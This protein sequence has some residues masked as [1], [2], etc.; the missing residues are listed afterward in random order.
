MLQEAESSRWPG[1]GASR[2][3]GS[4]AVEVVP[5]TANLSGAPGSIELN[6]CR[7]AGG[8]GDPAPDL[9]LVAGHPP[10]V[11]GVA[12]PWLLRY[13][14]GMRR[15]FFS[16]AKRC[17]EMV[18]WASV[19][20]PFIG[21]YAN[22]SVMEDQRGLFGFQRVE[23][24]DFLLKNANVVSCLVVALSLTWLDVVER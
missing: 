7:P 6:P 13:R 20:L 9:L 5:S 3:Q 18:R 2:M 12:P 11:D 15:E 1:L 17:E 14:E 19:G 10:V 4:G 24:N 22:S 8:S 21:L 23:L 16:R